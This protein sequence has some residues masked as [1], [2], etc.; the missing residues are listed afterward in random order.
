MVQKQSAN[1]I[2]RIEELQQYVRTVDHVKK[3]VAELESNRAANPKIINGI[4]GTIAR[5]LSHMRQRALTAN[6]GTLP[7]VAGSLAIVAG[8]AGTGINMKVRALADG[9]NSMTMQLDQALKS[10][11]EAPP[12]KDKDKDKDKEKTRS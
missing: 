10:A 3:L 11:H 5:E 8:R 7:D 12:E 6:L 4:C 1:Q 9:V 2:R